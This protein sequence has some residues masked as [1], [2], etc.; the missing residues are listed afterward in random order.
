MIVGIMKA[1]STLYRWLVEHPHVVRGAVKEANFLCD[2]RYFDG[3]RV[4]EECRGTYAALIGSGGVRI[5]ASPSY[6]DPAVAERKAQRLAWLAPEARVVALLRNPIARLRSHYMHEVLRGRESRTLQEALETAENDY[7]RRSCYFSG[8]SPYVVEFGTERLIRVDFEPL[9]DEATW[10]QL[11]ADLGLPWVRLP[12]QSFNKTADNVPFNALA[13]LLW[14]RGLLRHSH[15]LPRVVKRLG[16][17]A[18]F[19]T[20]GAIRRLEDSSR[21]PIPDSTLE[22]V[23]EEVCSLDRLLNDTPSWASRWKMP[24]A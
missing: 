11:L 8:L 20:R 9:N 23:H 1:G 12:E 19:R 4:R 6:A 15:R 10:S 22:L 5:D 18:L 2:D 17:L 21:G 7:T 13:L 16:K 14:E 24:P 3:H